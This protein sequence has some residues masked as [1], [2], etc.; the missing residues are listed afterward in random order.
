MEEEELQGSSPTN[1]TSPINNT[2]PK[3]SFTQLA[4]TVGTTPNEFSKLA[5][6]YSNNLHYNTGFGKSKYDEGFNFDA[7][8]DENDPLASVNEHRANNQSWATKSAAGIARIG[9]KAVSEIA[10]MPGYVGGAIMAIDAKEGEGFETAFN[11]KFIQA[12]NG[13]N[14]EV[15]TELLP[16]YVKKAVS[17][18]NLW[19]NISS[20]D[21]WATEG[22]DGI[23]YIASMFAPGAAIKALGVGHKAMG[24]TAKGLSMVNGEAKLN[25]AV[26][27][28]SNLGITA[29]RFD[30]AATAMANTLFESGAEAGSAM[31]ALD[32]QK[33][34]IIAKWL[35]EGMTPEQAEAQFTEQKGLLGRDIF[36]SNMGILLVPNL[37]QSKMIWG[38]GAPK[39]LT[40][41]DA[42]VKNTAK[43]AIGRIA[44]ATASEGFI[45]EAGQSTVEHMF[46][47]KAKRGQLNKSGITDDFN[48]GELADSYLDTISSTEGQKAMFLGAF[49]GGG[50][51]AYHGYKGD[52]AE[53]NQTNEVL[54]KS[55]EQVDNFNKI[56]ESD[57]YKRDADNK[58]IFDANN[59]PELDAVKV[60]EV[61]R[62]LKATEEDNAKFE[63]AALN[64]DYETVS[65]LKDKAITQLIRPYA[66]QGEMGIQALRQHLEE[67]SKAEEIKGLVKPEEVKQTIDK[68]VAQ[69]SYMQKQY[70]AYQDFSRELINIQHPNAK[71]EDV[72]SFYNHLADTFLTLKGIEYQQ[73]GKLTELQKQKD[74]LLADIGTE[75]I[76]TDVIIDEESFDDAFRY[77]HITDPRAKLLNDKIDKAKSNIKDIDKF[78]NNDVWN[79]EKVNES[80]ANIVEERNDIR[81]QEQKTEEIN[82]EIESIQQIN[83][84]A[85]LDKVK[86]D[87]PH[88]AEV[89]AKRREILLEVERLKKEAL[90]EEN[91]K[92]A[93]EALNTPTEVEVPTENAEVNSDINLDGNPEV[94]P[95]EDTPVQN[96]EN[97]TEKDVDSEI[98]K[99][100]PGAKVI[101]YNRVIKNVFNFITDSF[102]AY[103][104]NG[105]DKSN[106]K[107]EFRINN[108]IKNIESDKK[109]ELQQVEDSW[110][111]D[112]DD[113]GYP[114]SSLQPLLKVVEDRYAKQL[115]SLNKDWIKAV[116]LV[117]NKDF[118]DMQFLYD[119]LPINVQINN[120]YAPIETKPASVS[121]QKIFEAETLPMRKAIIDALANGQSISELS[122]NI[123]KQF[124]GQLKV[125]PNT[126][127][128]DGS[129]KTPE[130]SIRDLQ[131][132]KG[133]SEMEVMKE[134][135]KRAYF[136]DYDGILTNVV[137]R[138]DKKE[139]KSAHKGKGEVF[140]FIPQ[141][142]GEDFPLKL[143]FKRMDYDKAEAVYE[144]V[145]ALSTVAKTI[146]N[147]NRGSM[148][149]TE[150]LDTLQDDI[151]D[152]LM[153]AI[154]DEIDLVNNMES[155]EAEKTIDKLLD[156]LVFQKSKNKFTK[157]ELDEFGNLNLGSLSGLNRVTKDEL[158]NDIHKESIINFL[159]RKRHNVL[160]TKDDKFTFNNPNYVSYLLNNNIINT[161]AV[162][163]E[164]TFQGYSTIYVN[165]DI[166]GVKPKLKVPEVSIQ[167][168]VSTTNN[169]VQEIKNLEKSIEG[170]MI[171]KA[172][173]VPNELVEILQYVYEDISLTKENYP[174]KLYND[175][176]MGMDM[177]TR[178]DVTGFLQEL[179]STPTYKARMKEEVIKPRKV[180]KV[181][182]PV[183]DVADFS[184][185]NLVNLFGEPEAPKTVQDIKVDTTFNFDKLDS[186]KQTILIK[187]LTKTLNVTLD[188][189]TRDLIA[190]NKKAVFDILINKAKA[191]NENIDNL[192]KRCS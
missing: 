98:S 64:G 71:P 138:K 56:I 27:A 135:T 43:N 34:S 188:N 147:P 62:A 140:I 70:E 25:G 124:P 155:N 40:V 55:K 116:E 176:A 75:M 94:N 180:G 8:L 33:D 139:T 119:N 84:I 174:S 121:A 85:E 190:T 99:L 69:A 107:V 157:F 2:P 4:R 118:T 112:V 31:Q 81:S 30:V 134:L 127:Q 137:N 100:Q 23:G 105:K 160:I 130:N 162:V 172:S 110:K 192:I 22:A 175:G 38:K 54:A 17:E 161:N 51:A 41:G 14:E 87:N 120:V 1:N 28:L 150:F 5:K 79:S 149:M 104:R 123:V 20:I 159:S 158:L 3:Q 32:E 148:L 36:T 142:N 52:K 59:K 183:E 18:G 173:E 58:I 169:K 106:D 191:K 78:I 115:S 114:N 24:I 53:R 86:I 47:E 122:T 103:E 89:I 92:I 182:L 166:Q 165:R 145:K 37:I 129:M 39:A 93:E 72:E 90:D 45:E 42:T 66:T 21:F 164:P 178:P 26:R 73:K 77:E 111:E 83:D 128:E 136:V 154:G 153:F 171:F 185:T 60:V 7:Q 68:A 143:N 113:K 19:D 125:Q 12:I 152:K 187:K 133:M 44:G 177:L 146:D 156:I 170:R 80:F 167:Q 144:V 76:R 49:L 57:I 50:M 15:N 65:E 91:R 189:S 48:I 141:N 102:I 63:E 163:N 82:T 108:L 179:R 96:N 168:P 101:S 117:D 10:K 74:I 151:K 131:F 126:Q 67:T 95:E 186:T 88:I 181:G 11:N 184:G 9:V 16:V 109:K 61:A 132:F 97:L 35:S 46:S 13:F 6:A 29:N